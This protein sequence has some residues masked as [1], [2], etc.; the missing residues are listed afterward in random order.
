MTPTK[1]QPGASQPQV[2]LYGPGFAN[3]MFDAQV[4][5]RAVMTAMAEPATI[6][7]AKTSVG[8]CPGFSPAMSALALT[9]ADFETRVW[10]DSGVKS[11]A[12][13]Y[14][15]FQTGAPIV[16]APVEA[17]FAFVTR[18]R[19]MPRFSSFAQGSLDYPD[20]STT[21]IIEV[22][23]LDAN[24]GF[25]LRGP[26]IPGERR[27]L[28]DPLPQTFLADFV[29]NRAAF[30]CGIDIVLCCGTR[31]AALPRSTHLALADRG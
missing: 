16:S 5:F 18:P 13:A 17:T 21:V 14:V 24:S 11:E 8:Q 1:P 26:G 9:L 29:A 25:R 19:E 2:G 31:I 3:A 20:T 27:L 10:L 30:P 22:E 15:R 28:A 12:A 4:T 7:T 23:N 6:Q